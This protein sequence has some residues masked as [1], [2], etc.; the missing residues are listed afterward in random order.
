MPEDKVSLFAVGVV[1]ALQPMMSDNRYYVNRSSILPLINVCCQ[2]PILDF[3]PQTYDFDE[4]NKLISDVQC[5][6]PKLR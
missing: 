1:V 5:P 2:V 6:L 3:S 4:Q